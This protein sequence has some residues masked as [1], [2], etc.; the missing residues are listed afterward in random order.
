MSIHQPP[1]DSPNWMAF[2]AT[3]GTT[4][5]RKV[6]VATHHETSRVGGFQRAN[7]SGG[8]GEERKAKET[9]Q[10]EAVEDPHLFSPPYR[11]SAMLNTYEFFDVCTRPRSCPLSRNGGR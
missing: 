6:I 5:S 8:R 2:F 7:E 4:F 9:Q 10:V 1:I 3:Q 11:I